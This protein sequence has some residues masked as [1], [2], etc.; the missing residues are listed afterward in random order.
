MPEVN[1]VRTLACRVAVV[2]ALFATSKSQRIAAG[3]WPSWRGPTGMGHTTEKGLPI[4]WGG[5]DHKNILWK[6]PLFPGLDKAR[7]DNNQS[8]PIV[9]RGRVF[10]TTSYWPAG[11]TPKEF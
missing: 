10:V 9:S 5:K 4:T 8:S 11:V 6:R 1:A 2:F 7:L 3:D